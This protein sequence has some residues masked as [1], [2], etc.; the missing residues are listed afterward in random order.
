[1][2]RVV[3]VALQLHVINCIEKRVQV[4]CHTKCHTSQ[5]RWAERILFSGI[6]M[7]RLNILLEIAYTAMLFQRDAGSPGS[8][9][10]VL[11]RFFVCVFYASLPRL[12]RFMEVAAVSE[13]RPSLCVAVTYVRETLKPLKF[14]T[15]SRYIRRCSPHEYP[16]FPHSC[17][18]LRSKLP[19]DKD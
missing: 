16:I 1:M 13:R 18:S 9:S 8:W 2:R 17:S 6:F 5:V 3:G 10:A 12:L 4:L 19:F 14:R 7:M 15:R 11:R